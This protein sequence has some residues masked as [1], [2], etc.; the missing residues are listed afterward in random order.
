MLYVHLPIYVEAHTTATEQLT[1]LGV[2]HYML[3]DVLMT[4]S[5]SYIHYIHVRVYIA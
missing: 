1:S 4:C 5:F 2:H 3:T